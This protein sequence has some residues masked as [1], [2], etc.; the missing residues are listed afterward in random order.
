MPKWTQE[1]VHAKMDELPSVPLLRSPDGEDAGYRAAIAVAEAD[2]ALLT[3]FADALDRAPGPRPGPQFEALTE[4]LGEVGRD[5]RYPEPPQGD[6]A[7]VA[8]WA[9]RTLSPVLAAS[10]S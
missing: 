10:V 3:A 5:H 1:L 9:R 7:A 8:S 2:L 4:A 6:A